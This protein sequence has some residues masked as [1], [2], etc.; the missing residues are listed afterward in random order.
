LRKKG[1]ESGWEKGERE[2]ALE[3]H[4]ASTDK[5]QALA[6]LEK[7]ALRPRHPLKFF[8]LIHTTQPRR[9]RQ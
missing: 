9:N 4:K 6:T 2:R 3:A 7:V 1:A 8:V 5:A